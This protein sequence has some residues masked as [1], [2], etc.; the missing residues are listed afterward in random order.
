MAVSQFG[1]VFGRNDAPSLASIYAMD[2]QEQRFDRQMKQREDAAQRKEDTKAQHIINKSFDPTKV[3]TGTPQ[4]PMITDYVNKKRDEYLKLQKRGSMTAAEM[5]S[6]MQQDMATVGQYLNN[7]KL[8]KNNWGKYSTEFDK[9]GF[10]S[11]EIESLLREKMFFNKGEDGVI[12]PKNFEDIEWDVDGTL[13]SIMTENV[14]KLTVSQDAAFKDL[15]TRPKSVMGGT[16]FFGN[17]PNAGLITKNR[18][19]GTAKFDPLFFDV[20]QDKNGVVTDVVP[21][22]RDYYGADGNLY[23]DKSTGKEA[24]PVLEDEAFDYIY[25]G[26]NAARKAIIDQRVNKKVGELRKAGKE[27]DSTDID[28]FR[29]EEAL[30]IVQSHSGNEL[31]DSKSRVQSWR[32]PERPRAAKSSSDDEIDL[33]VAPKTTDGGYSVQGQ[34]GELNLGKNQ[35]TG[36]KVFSDDIIKYDDGRVKIIYSDRDQYNNQI[37]NQNEVVF[38]NQDEANKWLKSNRNL[39]GNK[40]VA[41]RLSDSGEKKDEP[42]KSNT[43]QKKFKVSWVK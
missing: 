35:K 33:S 17:T 16:F 27:V 13:Q 8:F 23:V 41:Q 9:Q 22:T 25:N 30:G 19:S 1:A 11:R 28:F 39:T 21:K 31:R 6:L 34:T 26:G 38:K 2:R 32:R 4:D 24:M 40:K 18:D 36:R 43:T 10:K 29:R 15:K 42:A 20:K 37:G 3:A 5:Q 12:S 7:A 14:D